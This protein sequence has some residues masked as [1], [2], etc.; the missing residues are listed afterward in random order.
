MSSYAI[1]RAT[2]KVIL[3]GDVA[4]TAWEHANTLEVD[5]FPWYTSGQKQGTQ[6]RLLYDDDA[7]YVQ[8]TCEDAHIFAKETELNGPVCLDSCV[9]FFA[10]F[11]PRKKPDY[12]NLEMNCCGMMHV[13]LGEQREGRRVITPELAAKIKLKASVPGPTKDESPYDN[14]WWIAAAMSFDMISEFAG[15]KVKP[16]SGTPW[17]ANFYR[18]GGKTDVQYGCWNFIPWHQPDFHRPEFFGDLT[19]A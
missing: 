14:G 11:D 13:G 3:T 19:F 4:G 18:C 16:A 17:R 7:I 6:A 5:N 12:F 1:N 15:Q 8:F 9:E 10:M 2:S